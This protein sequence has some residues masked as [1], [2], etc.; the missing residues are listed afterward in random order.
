M[1]CAGPVRCLGADCL[2]V[3]PEQS[4]DFARAAAGLQAAQL[5]A[6]DSDCPMTDQG[7]GHAAVHACSVFA[8]EGLECKRAVGGLVNCCET[9]DGVSLAEYLSLLMAVGKLDSALLQLGEGHV[10]R[11]AW[12]TLRAPFSSAWSEVT[13]PF[14]SVANN[15]LGSTT[16]A[17]S[18]AAAS[19]S[20]D[21]FGQQLLHETAGWVA[22]T[23]GEAA[24]NSL[25]SAGGA[26]PAVVGGVL[27]SGPLSRILQEQMRPQLGRGWGSAKDPNCEGIGVGQLALID[28]SQVNLDEWLVILDET[29]LLPRVA[30]LNLEA[31]TGAGSSLS[32]DGNRPEAAERSRLRTQDLDADALR[33]ESELELWGTTLP[34]V[35]R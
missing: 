9:P 16:P 34:G 27:D 19:L 11:G 23:F 32:L 12:E 21:A 8:G 13:R 4:S 6:M 14:T 1:D 35:P 3:Q 33:R 25:F 26:S 17:A 24:A 18:D 10:L 28:W 29:G 22:E 20:V 5:M 15:L 30:T 31:L 2:A 7:G